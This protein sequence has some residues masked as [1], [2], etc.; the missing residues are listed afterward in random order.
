MHAC[1]LQPRWEEEKKINKNWHIQ[2]D[3]VE[4]DAH[5]FLTDPTELVQYDRSQLCMELQEASAAAPGQQ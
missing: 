1:C 4:T 3:D 5:N 2:Y